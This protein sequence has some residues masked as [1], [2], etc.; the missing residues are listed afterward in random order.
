MSSQIKSA[1]AGQLLETSFKMAIQQGANDEDMESSFSENHDEQTRLIPKQ[2]LNDIT[3][4]LNLTKQ[5]S[6]LLTQSPKDFNVLSPECKIHW[7]KDRHEKFL[8]FFKEED[9]ILFCK[10]IE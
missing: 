5:Q 6:V 7:Y 9:H 1:T 2:S 8:L 10:D 3:K 4:N